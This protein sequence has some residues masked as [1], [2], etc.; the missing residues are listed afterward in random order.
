MLSQGIDKTKTIEELEGNR[1][2][3]PPSDATY[4]VQSVHEL[5]RRP[6]KDLGVDGLRRLITQNVG[7]RWLL[8]VAL[9][10]LRETAPI[11]AESGFYDDDLLHA[12][13]TRTEEIWRN[14]PHLA[15]HLD[16]TIN[17]LTDILPDMQRLIAEWR[18]PLSDML[19][20]P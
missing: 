15:H 1:W 18:A 4:L 3:D 2:P 5:R 20:L 6:I 8:P 17:L 19:G 12:V 11:E 10:H 16:E 14:S 13:L 7:L 9:D